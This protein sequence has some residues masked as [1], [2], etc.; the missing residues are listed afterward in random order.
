VRGG[1]KGCYSLRRS[2]P[3]QHPF[4]RV[5]A[6]LCA[7]PPRL[8]FPATDGAGPGAFFLLFHLQGHVATGL[9]RRAPAPPGIKGLPA[10][11]SRSRRPAPRS[12]R[13]EPGSLRRGRA[14]ALTK[15]PHPLRP[16][17]A[18]KSVQPLVGGGGS[19][20]WLRSPALG[21]PYARA[22]V[23]PPPSANTPLPSSPPPPV[24]RPPSTGAS[25][26]PRSG[27]RAPSPGRAFIPLPTSP[28]PSVSVTDVPAQAHAAVS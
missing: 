13:T 12:P 2:A 4:L 26:A 1:L 15:V 23:Q 24:K 16:S 9:C 7:R 27:L 10:L 20:A 6:S 8:S 14:S 25:G 18:Q 28:R 17:P 3:P 5:L 19:V 22:L 21:A 11:F